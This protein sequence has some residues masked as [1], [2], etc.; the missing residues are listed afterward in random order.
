MKINILGNTKADLPLGKSVYNFSFTLPM[1][2]PSSFEAEFGRVRHTCSV[3]IDQPWRFDTKSKRPFSVVDIYDLNSD[4]E[5]PV[6]VLINTQWYYLSKN[7]NFAHIWLL[8]SY[9]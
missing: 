3:Q 5:A 9:F 2:I 6:S 7:Q 8:N 4:L 1:N